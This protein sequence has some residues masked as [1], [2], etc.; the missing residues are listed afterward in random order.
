[1]SPEGNFAATLVMRPAGDP[2][3]AALRSFV[4]ALALADALRDL[5]GPGVTIALKW[6][7]PMQRMIRSKKT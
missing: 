6:P 3:A 7:T 5:C 4:A 2:A 1:M